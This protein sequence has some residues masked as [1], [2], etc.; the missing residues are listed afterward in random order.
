MNDLSARV[1]RLKL[2]GELLSR[3]KLLSETSADARIELLKLDRR[4]LEI[5]KILGAASPPARSTRRRRSPRS[6]A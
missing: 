6:T 4:M 1:A 2:I 3:K 5:R